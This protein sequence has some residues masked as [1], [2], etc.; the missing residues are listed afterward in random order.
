MADVYHALGLHMHQPWEISGRCISPANA[1][2]RNRSCGVTTGDPHAG[3]YEDVARLHLSF[4]GTLLKQLED[5]AV[6]QISRRVVKHP[7]ILERYR[8]SNIEFIAAA[9]SPGL[10][11]D[12]PGGLGMRRPNGGKGLGR[13][14][15]G[16]DGSR[17]FGRR[18]WV[19]AWK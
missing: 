13:H 1:G 12:S 15:L 5:E 10:P 2:R 7:E 19:F 16:R 9:V 14:L 18:K 8:R 11:A 4:S 17:D 6:R 3:G